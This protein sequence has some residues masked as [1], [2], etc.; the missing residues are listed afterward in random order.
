VPN[1]LG[2]WLKANGLPAVVAIGGACAAV[3]WGAVQLGQTFEQMQNDLEQKDKEIAAL[4]SDM[5]DVDKRLND[6][7]KA[8]SE[9]KSE[10]KDDDNTLKTRLDI[11]DALSKY[12]TDRALS[13][14]P[15]V[16]TPAVITTRKR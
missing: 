6:I 11:I 14:A 1:S 12:A 7:T 2:D 4:H 10:L 3:L 8:I 15:P 13:P 16:V 5:I 9:A